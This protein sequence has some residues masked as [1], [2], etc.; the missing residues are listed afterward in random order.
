MTGF[1]LFSNLM[2]NSI[3]TGHQEEFQFLQFWYM[4]AY[5]SLPLLP[6]E[7]FKKNE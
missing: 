6:G 1:F 2:I 3:K 5:L 4:Q 7:Y